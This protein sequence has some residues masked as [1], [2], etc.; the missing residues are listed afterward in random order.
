MINDIDDI[1]QREMEKDGNV[2]ITEMSQPSDLSELIF[3]DRLMHFNGKMEREF[4][5][6]WYEDKNI[7]ENKENYKKGDIKK[8]AEQGVDSYK[9]IG[10]EYQKYGKTKMTNKLKEG[11]ELP[12]HEN[13]ESH[14]MSEHN[15]EEESR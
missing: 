3:D 10:E 2:I 1:I 13:G 15:D 8:F 7:K 9:K 14:K 4:H 5:P 11:D 6:E 12:H